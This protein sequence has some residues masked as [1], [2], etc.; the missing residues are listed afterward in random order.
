[1][2]EV[3]S[4]PVDWIYIVLGFLVFVVVLGFI[5]GGRNKS[6]HGIGIEMI[7][8][9]SCIFMKSFSRNLGRPPG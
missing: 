7:C 4:I 5:I 1:M 3:I 6:Q 9:D 2:G 8:H